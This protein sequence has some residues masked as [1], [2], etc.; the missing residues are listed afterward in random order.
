MFIHKQLM[1]FLLVVAVL[2]VPLH[3]VAKT[4]MTAAGVSQ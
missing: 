2:L 1:A 3:S 4:I